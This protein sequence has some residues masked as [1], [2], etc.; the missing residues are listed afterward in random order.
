MRLPP[1][2]AVVRSQF[3]VLIAANL[4]FFLAPLC[5]SF[6]A[7][8]RPAGEIDLTTDKIKWYLHIIEGAPEQGSQD[9][10]WYSEM[11]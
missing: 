4:A 5:H 10:L 6:S 11:L 1:Q 7:G 2:H 9:W 3:R 8:H